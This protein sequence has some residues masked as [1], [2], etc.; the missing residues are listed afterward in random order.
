[1]TT[2]RPAAVLTEVCSRT[3]LDASDAVPL[4]QHAATLYLFDA[5]HLVVRLNRDSDDRKRARTVV[6][7]TRWLTQ[8]DFPSVAPADVEQPLDIDDY[9][10]TLWR[11][12]P[13][14]NRPKPT[15]DH[16]GTMLRQLHALPT[17]PVELSPYQPLKTSVTLWRTASLCRLVTVR[18]CSINGPSYSAIMNDS[19]FPW[20]TAGFTAMPTQ[21]TR[22]GTATGHYWATGMRS[23][24]DHENLT[25]S[26]P[27][28]EPGSADHKPNETHSPQH[29]ATMSPHG[30]ASA[31]YGKCETSTL[32]GLTFDSPTLET[33]RRQLSWAGGSTH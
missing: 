14:H 24:P 28:K 21:E 10:V 5:A 9:T 22:Y 32:S 1:M 7:L 4:H 12:Y 25:S 26:T 3:G 8:Q 13:Q 30:Q 2:T 31:Y 15:A 23:A 11:Y 29:M 20:D 18:G 16:L 33:N 6:K 27:T 17:P 19:T